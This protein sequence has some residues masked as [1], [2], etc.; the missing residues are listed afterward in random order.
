M[1]ETCQLFATSPSLAYILHPPHVLFDL[2]LA[3]P[4]LLSGCPSCIACS[5]LARGDLLLTR[6]ECLQ[7]HTSI[8]EA[9]YKWDQLV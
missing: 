2:V 6:L 7:K 1:V 4:Q 9:I 8:E 3:Q 5:E